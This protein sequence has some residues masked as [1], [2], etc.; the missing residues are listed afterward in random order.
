MKT[1]KIF[2]IFDDKQ[3]ILHT[4]CEPVEMPISDEIKNTLKEM[5]NYLKCSQDEEFSKKHNIRSGVGLAAPQIGINK[6]FY[7][8]Y[9]IDSDDNVVEYGL[10]NPKIISSSVK[11]CALSGGEGCLSVNK[12]HE[13]LVYRYYKITLTAYDVVKDKN[14]T[15]TAKGYDAIVLQHELDHLNGVVYYDRINKENPLQQIENSILI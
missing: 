14:I 13:G 4:F 12:D 1:C 10:V 8:I 3:K 15:I 2:K 9:Y 7:A 5:I 11:L 6:R